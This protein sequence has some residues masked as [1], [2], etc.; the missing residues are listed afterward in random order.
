VE[1]I[2]CLHPY[3]MLM[4]RNLPLTVLVATFISLSS[5]AQFKSISSR[6]PVASNIRADVQKVVA[7]FPYQF[8]SIRGEVIDKGPQSI[9]YAS[10]LQVGD[11]KQCSIMQ[12]SS[13]TKYIYS[14]QAMMLVTEDFETAAKKYKSIYQQLRGANVYYVKDQYTLK[15]D[16]DVAEESTGFATSTL[17]LA[18]PPVPLQK[19]RIDI[20]L[21]FEFPEWKVSLVVYEKER[22]D[23]EPG[24]I[25]GN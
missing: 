4:K 24:D 11:L 9:E 18:N 2:L 19:L 20:D 1:N 16:Y 21:Q 17:A 6:L 3:P 7:D 8:K 13:G 15:G 12:Y 10:L 5:S 25:I 23:D 14:W 22:E